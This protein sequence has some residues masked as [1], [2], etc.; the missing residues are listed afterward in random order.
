MKPGFSIRPFTPDDYDGAISVHLSVYPEYPNTANEWRDADARRHPDLF[1][2]RFVAEMDGKIV[3]LVGGGPE[4]WA[5]HPGLVSFNI[6]VRP[7]YEGRG[8]GAELYDRFLQE[9]A[10]LSP[11]RITSEAREDKPKGIRFLTKRG[12]V[13]EMRFWESQLDVDAFD[14]TPYAGCEE[15]VTSQGIAIKTYAELASDPD[16]DRKLYEMDVEISLE[17]PAPDPITPASFDRYRVQVLESPHLLPDAIFVA[18]DGD[19]Y[20]GITS[21]WRVEAGEHLMTGLTGVRR[22][23]RRKGIALALKLRAID[24]ARRHGS[25]QIRTDNES[26]NRPMLAINERLG[27]VKTPAWI[28]FALTGDFLPQRHEDT[29]NEEFS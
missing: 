17:L 1:F 19:R 26:N 13:E 14:F 21:L 5:N 22:D 20:V 10:V 18:L 16:R 15:R 28:A 2:R 25:P 3:G 7:E 24:Y 4:E 11:T 29:K 9:A 23:Y 27:F 12:F 6:R 8:I